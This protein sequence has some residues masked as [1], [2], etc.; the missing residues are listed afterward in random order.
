[1]YCTVYL[2]VSKLTRGVHVVEVYHTGTL[3]SH[4]DYR[5]KK[6]LKNQYILIRL[7]LR[8]LMRLLAVLGSATLEDA[9]T[10]STSLDFKDLVFHKTY[11]SA[12]ACR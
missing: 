11:C 7:Q 10:E 3:N 2:N 9:Y 4:V 12:T 6:N 8:T 1:M 5:V